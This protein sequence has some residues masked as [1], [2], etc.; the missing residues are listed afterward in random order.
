MSKKHNIRAGI[1]LQKTSVN[2][3]SRVGAYLIDWYIA[4]MFAGIPITLIATSINH[5]TTI[6]QDLSTL[7]LGLAV[8]AGILAIVFYLG[9]YFVV[10]LK[11]YKGQSFG[12][13]IFKLKVVK[14]DGSDVDFKTI[15]L[16]EGLGIM[17]VEGY[18][19]NSSSY[20][21][22]ILQLFTDFNIMDL[23]VYLFGII[24][25]VS[26]L[27]GLASPSRKMIHDFIAHTHIIS[28][29]DEN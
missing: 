7:P 22:Q 16:R 8:L 17:I 23:A 26:I 21:R 6:T 12:K 24:S 3:F 27:I 14:D 28:T 19:A 18:L 15:L 10:E 4:S 5:N 9:Y 25:A 1:Q 2:N 20:L 13:R 29:K 11:V